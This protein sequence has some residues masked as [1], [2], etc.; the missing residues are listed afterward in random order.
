VTLRCLIV[1]DSEEFLRSA[2]RLLES[3]GVEVVG[4]ASS[5]ADAL[6]LTESLEPDL[7]LV[8]VELGHEDG[9]TLGNELQARRPAIRVVLISA[10]D[11]EAFPDLSS[12]SQAIGFLAKRDL[13]A[14]AI[15][16]LLAG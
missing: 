12:E 4:S 6:E 7:A 15:E 16:D 8:D 14:A 1:D 11:R 13:S 2:S 5:G 10:Y 3:Q 9:V